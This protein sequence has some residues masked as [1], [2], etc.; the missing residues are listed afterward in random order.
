MV[1]EKEAIAFLQH[2]P[3]ALHVLITGRDAPAS[4]VDIADLVTDMRE[5]RHPFKSGILAQKGIEF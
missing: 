3:S 1:E 2:K 5:V 4:L